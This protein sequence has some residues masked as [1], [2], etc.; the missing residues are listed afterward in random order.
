MGV[1]YPQ[2]CVGWK[3]VPLLVVLQSIQS[4]AGSTL[5]REPCPYAQLVAAQHTTLE[6]GSNQKGCRWGR[7]S[8]S[9]KLLLLGM[10][11]MVTPPSQQR[12]APGPHHLTAQWS[13]SLLVPAL[14]AGE[15]T[16]PRAGH[17]LVQHPS[18]LQEIFTSQEICLSHGKGQ[19]WPAQ[20]ERPAV[21]FAHCSW[22]PPRSRGS[23]L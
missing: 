7:G 10:L 6:K 17:Q 18:H 14:R 13:P 11:T 8:G 12:L 21:T 2:G 4:L 3:P 15:S 22:Q 9:R 5:K 1:N 19:R 20:E 16:S 23:C